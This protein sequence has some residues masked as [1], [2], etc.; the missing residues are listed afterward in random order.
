MDA[1]KIIAQEVVH[2]D[3]N[4]DEKTLHLKIQQKEHAMFPQVMEIVAK[5]I[6]C[7]I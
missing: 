3:P 7:S 2:V 5:S 4:D 6:V 1:G